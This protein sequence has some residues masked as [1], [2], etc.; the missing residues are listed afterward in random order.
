MP[1]VAGDTV[2]VVDLSGRL[3]ALTRSRGEVRWMV[4]LPRAKVWSGPVLAGGRLWLVSS[5]GLLIGVSPQDGRIQ[6]KRALGE[7]VYIAPV[8]ANGHMYIYTDS[9]RLIALHR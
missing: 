3:I 2:F 5:K 8:I 4:D 9:A 6:V 7:K 1:W